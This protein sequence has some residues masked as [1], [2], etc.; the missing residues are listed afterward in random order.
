[1]QL[2]HL[3]PFLL[4]LSS[5]TVLLFVALVSHHQFSSPPTF[6]TADSGLAFSGRKPS[7]PKDGGFQSHGSECISSSVKPMPS[8]RVSKECAWMLDLDALPGLG[9]SSHHQDQVVETIFDRSE[10]QTSNVRLQS[11]HPTNRN[12]A[13]K[14]LIHTL[15]R[16]LESAAR[17]S[18][19]LNSVLDIM[20]NFLRIMIIFATHSTV[21]GAC[22]T[23]CI[24][25]L[26]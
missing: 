9:F 3:G 13:K 10:L 19:L 12:V 18:F 22:T 4:G 15:T 23:S 24:D 21:R 7:V 6:T 2:T 8:A 17:I 25:M 14:V 20:E 11:S 5:A 1:M 26:K 16:W